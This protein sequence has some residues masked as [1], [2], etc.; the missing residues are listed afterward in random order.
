MV[1]S[2]QAVISEGIVAEFVSSDCDVVSIGCDFMLM[3]V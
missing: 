2:L 3:S 1:M